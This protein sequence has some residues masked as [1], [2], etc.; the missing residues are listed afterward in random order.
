MPDTIEFHVD[1]PEST[2]EIAAEVNEQ[3]GVG[4]STSASWRA[5]SRQA[6]RYYRSDQYRLR[7]RADMNRIRMVA[8]F[9]RR[10]V[11]KI[12]NKILDSEPVIT[13]RGRLPQ[14]HAFARK[15]LQTLEWTRDE[16]ENWEQYL[17]D[18]ITDQAH[19]GEGVLFE[20]VDP[21]ADEGRGMPITKWYDSRYVLWDPAAREWQRGD[22]KWI[23]LLEYLPTKDIQKQY[24]LEEEPKPEGIEQFLTASQL[25]RFKARM[26]QNSNA[27]GGLMEDGVDR[28]WVKR[29]WS[30]KTT[31]QRNFFQD[32]NPAMFEEGGEQFEMTGP[33]Y[34]LMDEESRMGIVELSTPDVELWETIVVG[35]QLLRHRLSPFDKKNGGHGHYPFGFFQGVRL[36]DE[37]RARGEI[38]FLI[39]VSD[40]RNEVLST[41]LDTAFL[42]NSGYINVMKGSVNPQNRQ[43]LQQIGR[44]WPLVVES[45]PGMPPPDWR[46]INP[47]SSQAFASLL[48]IM[49]AVQ[50][51]ESGLTAFDRGE[52]ISKEYSG[53]AI[54]ALQAETAQLGVSM[55][56]HVESGMKRITLLR[57][58]NIAQFMRGSRVAEVVDEETG[59][60]RPLFIGHDETEIAVMNGLQQVVGP[61]NEPLW[62]TPEGNPAEILALS[63][64]IVRD[65]VFDRIKL[66]LDTNREQNKIEREEMAA[67]ILNM[68]GLGVLPWFAQ[69]VNLS[70]QEMLLD[71]LQEMNMEKQIVAKLTEI[72]KTQNM[73]PQQVLQ[74][75]ER[76]FARGASGAGAAP[77]QPPVGAMPQ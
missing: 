18:G 10:D 67:N 76:V 59:E 55:R 46:G 77:G 58:H 62:V 72:G 41:M 2:E 4:F 63:D 61:N 50:D 38:G 30:K 65:Q 51:R 32:G 44:K 66:K 5:E 74:M 73:E 45:Q 3:T 75:L 21:D 39:G 60:E 6:L 36:R 17:E 54:R 8:N 42:A 64:T 57:L 28:A 52:L 23:I 31:Y 9:V 1:D 49:D 29:R 12:K 26:T 70:N 33:Q 15:L 20:G 24:G 19:V 16:E 14:H 43:K 11:D 56:K 40:V 37:P 48:P 13:P 69:E 68:G 47:A 7:R 71:G 25:D 22:A 34:D 35:Q 53:R 27:L